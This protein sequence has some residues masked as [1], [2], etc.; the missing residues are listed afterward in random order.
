[1]PKPQLPSTSAADADLAP[2]WWRAHVRAGLRLHLR[3]AGLA[4]AGVVV[5]GALTSVWLSEVGVTVCIDEA[6]ASAKVCTE[7]H[8]HPLTVQRRS[9]MVRRGDELLFRR[10]WHRSGAVWIEGGYIDGKRSGPWTER[11]ADGAL[12]FAGNYKNDKLHG[13]ETWHFPSGAPE[14][15]IG[16]LEGRRDGE[17]RWWHENGALRR[18][19]QWRADEKHGTFTI[20]NEHGDVASTGE[21][22]NGEYVSGPVAGDDH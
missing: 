2:R 22:R 3:R 16:R 1:M 21:Y 12:R 10:E 11:Y 18:I 5:L 7:T 14:W 15:Q 17:E 6:E 8:F 13:V 20:F 19:G 4:A 9:E